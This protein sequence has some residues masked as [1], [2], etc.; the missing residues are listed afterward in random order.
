MSRLNY[1]LIVVDSLREDHIHRRARTP[2]L[3]SLDER[4]YVRFD[5]AY[6]TECWTFPS[7][8]SMFTGLMPSVH[9]S[10]FQNM[11]YRCKWMT[12]AEILRQSGYATHLITRNTVFDGSIE[13]A[14]R[15]FWTREMPI[16]QG[17]SPL[18]L[19]AVL[20]KPRVRSMIQK[21]GFFGPAQKDSREFLSR[22]MR[23]GTPADEMALSETYHQMAHDRRTATPSFTFVNLYDMHLPYPPVRDSSQPPP[24][25]WDNLNEIGAAIRAL[26]RIAS[27]EYLEDGFRLDESDQRAIR[28]RY[29][30]AAELM[31]EK[32]S[33]FLMRCEAAGLLED[34]VVIITSDHG[35]AFGEHGLWGHDASVYDIHT[36][37]PLFIKHP[38]FDGG[39]TSDIVS[40]RDLY[41]VLTGPEEH[42]ILEPAARAKSPLACSEHIPYRTSAPVKKEYRKRQAAV[43]MP[44]GRKIVARGSRL[45][46][47]GEHDKHELQPHQIDKHTAFRVLRHHASDSHACEAFGYLVEAGG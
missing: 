11:E 2:C 19:L 6:T 28:R 7:H 18:D 5:Q 39:R 24:T 16:A 29:A 47:Y 21:T 12:A 38:R 36:H 20:A 41:D 27:H 14:C 35:E 31:D 15:G 17:W 32:I 43:K 40:L 23:L 37:V 4:G 1:L 22:I 26:P 44:D 25:T 46:I 13:G 42:S 45:S 10:T 34:T 3:N 30:K 8:M 33:A 9:G